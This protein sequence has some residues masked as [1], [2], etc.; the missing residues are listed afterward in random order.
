MCIAGEGIRLS[1][2]PGTA[3]WSL[4]GPDV[5]SQ[6][7]KV[8]ATARAIKERRTNIGAILMSLMFVSPGRARVIGASPGDGIIGEVLELA[9]DR[10]AA[11]V[12]RGRHVLDD[13]QPVGDL[14]DLELRRV[15]QAAVRVA[16]PQRCGLLEDETIGLELDVVPGIP[17]RNL[18]LNR[19]H[20]AERA[21]RDGQ[22]GRAEC[23]NAARR[24]DG[25][26]DHSHKDSRAG[27]DAAVA[28]T[29]APA[30]ATSPTALVRRL[31]DGRD[32]TGVRAG[33]AV[34]R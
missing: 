28:P 16:H 6:A 4:T 20:R 5:S 25:L 26:S 1:C 9:C 23:D 31:E 21:W 7:T 14:G 3:P 10:E 12:V 22:P 11:Q 34:I 2:G 8:N 24:P 29:P 33:G 19:H 17:G 13:L 27:V 15:D 30:A 18:R 32:R